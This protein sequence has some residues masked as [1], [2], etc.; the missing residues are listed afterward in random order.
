MHRE[1]KERWVKMHPCSDCALDS[2]DLSYVS[3]DMSIGEETSI[4]V[5]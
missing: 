5:T 2:S 1:Q 4:N 3:S